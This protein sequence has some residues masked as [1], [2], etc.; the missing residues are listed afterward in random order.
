MV[1]VESSGRCVCGFCVSVSLCYCVF[2]RMCVCVY[3]SMWL[4][5]VVFVSMHLSCCLCVFLCGLVC[6][7]VNVCG[8]PVSINMTKELWLNDSV[9]EIVW[10]GGG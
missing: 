5:L 1:S 6:Y 10:K 7:Y 2:L 9:W 4:C 3:V 8:V